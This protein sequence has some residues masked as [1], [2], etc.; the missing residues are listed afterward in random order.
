M[1]ILIKTFKICSKTCN[2]IT[3]KRQQ[4]NF[5]H[6]LWIKICFMSHYNKQKQTMRIISKI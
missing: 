1:E 5:C 4:E 3:F 2:K 6:N